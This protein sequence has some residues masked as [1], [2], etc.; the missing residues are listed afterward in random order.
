[1]GPD[2][3]VFVHPLALCESDR[4]GP[5]TRI[6]AF[7]HVLAGA[8]I[9]AGCNVCDHAYVE[10]GVQVGDGVTIKNGVQ[11][12]EGVTIEDDV[13]LGPNCI[14]TNDLLPRAAIKRHG[15]ELLTTLVRQGATIGANATIVCGVTV[16]PG[17]LV[18]AGAVVAADVP[19][20]ALV[21]GNPAR[22][23]RW[24]CTCG[25]RPDDSLVCQCGRAYRLVSETEGLA[26][27]SAP[28]PD[29]PVMGA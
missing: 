3:E 15:E 21:A 8:V 10:Y 12:F 18:A 9:G 23:L 26:L 2:A 16:G 25:A 27:V 24:V 13:F 20:H 6:W 5:G 28:P 17:A 22:R 4:V 29:G 19:A 11:L 7:A 1:M 14:F